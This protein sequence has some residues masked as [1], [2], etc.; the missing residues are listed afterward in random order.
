MKKDENSK[1]DLVNVIIVTVI[2]AALLITAAVLLFGKKDA[3]R[4]IEIYSVG[5]E[6]IVNRSGTG[7]MEAYEGMVL[8]SGDVITVKDGSVNLELDDDKYIVAESYTEFELIATG[9]SKKS[10]TTININYGTVKN[11]IDKKLKGDSSY[12]VNTPNASLSVRGTDFMVQVY[13]VSGVVYTKNTVYEGEVATSIKYADGSISG[14]EIMV[15]D[16]KEITIYQKGE[17][18]DYLTDVQDITYDNLPTLD[19]SVNSGDVSMIDGVGTDNGGSGDG[20][21]SSELTTDTVKA[22]MEENVYVIFNIFWYGNLQYN[23][24]AV[25]N[26]SLYPV[27]DPA[28]PDYASLENYLSSVYSEACVDQLLD[29]TLYVNLDGALYIDA[30]YMT[31]SGYYTDWTNATYEITSVSDTEATFTVTGTYI[32]PDGSYTEPYTSTGTVVFENGKWLLTS[33]IE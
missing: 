25:V 28:F 23:Y 14:E 20:T 26:D 5:G 30:M 27:T 32:A 9:T 13:E 7:E 2:I 8:E 31:G 33:L 18:V 15:P 1:A 17:E 22:L 10:K 6:V 16:G 3:Y 19:G 21:A 29:G 12:E 24:D 11:N 4:H